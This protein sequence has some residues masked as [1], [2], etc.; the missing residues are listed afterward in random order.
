MLDQVKVIA[1][2]ADDTLWLNEVYFRES[3]EEFFRMLADYS[4][5]HG[6]EK[7]LIKTEIAN[8][9]PYGYGVKS[10]ILSMI[11]TALRVTDKTLHVEVIDRILE[12]GKAQLRKPVELLD[13]VEDVL[14]KLNGT[15]K[16]ILATKGDLLDQE[17]KLEQSGL[18]RHFHHI[19]VLSHKEEKNYMKLLK[20]LDIEPREF[21]MV[22]NSLKSDVIPVLNIGGH[23]FHV[24]YPI[25]WAL[26]KVDTKIEH[27][28]L[29][30]LNSITEVLDHV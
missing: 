18:E 22:G 10:F 4:I 21:L 7:E 17:R 30:L 14:L 15:Y 19:E 2:D 13:G 5:P 3:E 20:H 26:E 16:L 28:N 9:A 25:T 1:F 29:K 11:E 27:P 8:V 6:L 23:A 12:L 24:P